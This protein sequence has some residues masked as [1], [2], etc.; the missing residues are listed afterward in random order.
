MIK[1]KFVLIWADDFKTE[2]PQNKI[3]SLQDH[4]L[5]EGEIIRGVY[6]C[7]IIDLI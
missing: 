7:P 2:D 5:V 4:Y 3:Y 1:K 6:F